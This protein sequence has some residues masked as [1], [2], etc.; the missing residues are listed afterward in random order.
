MARSAAVIKV[1]NRAFKRALRRAGP[2]V[3]KEAFKEVERS[4]K[5]I[6]DKTMSGF[7]HAGAIAPLFHGKPGMRNISGKAR[8]LYRWSI[9]KKQMKGRVGLL[10]KRSSRRAFYLS[11]FM[12]GTAT[13]AARPVHQIASDSEKDAFEAAQRAALRRVFRKLFGAD[14]VIG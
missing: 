6:Y 11:F 8:R 4:T 13:Q 3:Q 2:E 12:F 14:G 10:T 1:D 7:D 9:S 5:A